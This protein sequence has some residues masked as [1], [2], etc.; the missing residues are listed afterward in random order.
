MLQIGGWL[1][2]DKITKNGGNRSKG[3]PFSK[4]LGRKLMKW[5]PEMSPIWAMNECV[6]LTYL[7]PIKTQRSKFLCPNV[8]SRFAPKNGLA[9]NT[10]SQLDKS[11]IVHVQSDRDVISQR[12]VTFQARR[13]LTN[14][15]SSPNMTMQASTTT[16]MMM[17]MMLIK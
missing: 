6:L 17:M 9:L 13:S 4:G 5:C 3:I 2:D 16:M 12:F 14:A 1:Q 7:F 8:E 15:P 11:C 10:R